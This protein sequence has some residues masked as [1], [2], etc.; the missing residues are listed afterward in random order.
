VKYSIKLGEDYMNIKQL[1][2]ISAG[3]AFAGSALLM[4][5]TASAAAVIYNTGDAT[6][7]TVAL[8]VN[9]EGHLNT[10]PNITVNASATGLATR[11]TE[12]T[13]GSNWYDA[14]SPGCLCEGWGAAANGIGSDASIDSG[15]VNNLTVD[16]FA[17][18]ASTATSVVHLTS[19][20]DLQVTHAYQPSTDSANVFEAVVTLTNTGAGT[21]TD[22]RYTRAMDWDIPRDE[23][24]EYVT[25]IGT[26]TTTDLL[27]SDDNGFEQPNPL[28][29]RFAY[30]GC[31]AGTTV[32]MVDCGPSDHGAVFDFGFGDLAAGESRTFSIFYGAAATE[33]LALATISDIGA[34]L[35]SFGQESGDPTGGTPATYI[36]AFKG[37]GGSVIIPPS[38][39][40]PASILLMGLGLLGFGAVRRRNRV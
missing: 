6:T 40:E 23:F 37:V 16:S 2:K 25:I 4:A 9:D 8:G 33:A 20:P 38:V 10:A 3:M 29:S 14:T 11:L 32:D 7:A 34:E 12:P 13:G 5:N 31:G 28:G 35:F 39:P 36:F 15:G 27:Y 24:N 30:G 26:A 19:L 18:T 1:K 21:L 22:V 17:S